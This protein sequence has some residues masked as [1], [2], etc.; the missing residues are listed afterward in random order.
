MAE[1]F[2]IIDAS[3]TVGIHPEHRLDMSVDKLVSVMDKNSVTASLVIATI[4]MFHQSETGNMITL[5]AARSSN[6]LLPVGTVNPRTYFG[7]PTDMQAIRDQG[8]KIFK[9]YPTHQRWAINSAAFAEVLR[10][11]APLRMPV[12]VD[13]GHPGDATAVMNAAAGYEAPI[14]FCSISLDTLSEALTIMSH[15]SNVMIETHELH[16]P[17][18]LELIVDRVGADRIIYGSG[19]PLRSI[20]SSLYYVLDSELSDEDKQKI[21]GGN[22]KRILGAG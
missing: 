10:Q 9:F 4:A 3:T 19:A 18:A 6:R 7:R 5:D 20:A 21:L 11:L 2:Q 22:I 16:V 15:T 14:V 12:M 8:F 17:E 1:T 13:I